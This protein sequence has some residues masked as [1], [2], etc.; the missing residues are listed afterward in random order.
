M[1][2]EMRCDDHKTHYFSLLLL[3]QTMTSLCF[4]AICSVEMVYCIP[5][6]EENTDMRNASEF[7]KETC[8]YT[9]LH[10]FHRYITAIILL[11]K[12]L[13]QTYYDQLAA[14]ITQAN[15]VHSL[16]GS[17]SDMKTLRE[18]GT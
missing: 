2:V 6:V 10:L 1:H 8:K 7:S 11:V 17:A 12:A 15:S 16:V 3:K 18:K 13:H 14:I 4:K 5:T 9:F